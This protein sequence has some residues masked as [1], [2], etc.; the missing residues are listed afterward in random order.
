MYTQKDLMRINALVAKGPVKKL[1]AAQ[2]MADSI[3]NGEKAM[4]RA[5]AAIAI[6]MQNIANIFIEKARLL[7]IDVNVRLDAPTKVLGSDLPES[8]RHQSNATTS[9]YGRVYG[10]A[11]LPCGKLNLQ[12]GNNRYFNVKTN[13][14]SCI[15]VWKVPNRGV[16]TEPFT[17]K[18]VITSGTTPIFQIGSRSC[19]VHDQNQRF[20]FEGEMVDYITHDAMILLQDKYGSRHC[21]VYK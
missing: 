7:G 20:M 10:N 14:D 19:F 2:R 21:Y 4:Q 11:I 1:I 3:K 12:T 16:S 18:Y 15:E 6:G 9:R 8:E 17:Y 13:G 5:S